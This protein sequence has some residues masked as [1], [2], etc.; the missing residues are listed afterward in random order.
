MKK[1][2][3]NSYY[4][5]SKEEAETIVDDAEKFLERITGATKEME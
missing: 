4:E 1:Q 3:S 5:L 2:N